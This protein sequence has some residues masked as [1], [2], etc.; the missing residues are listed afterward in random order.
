MMKK[1]KDGKEYI[2]LQEVC[3]YLNKHFL[4]G[5]YDFYGLEGITNNTVELY[6]D[7]DTSNH[8]KFESDDVVFIGCYVD[9]LDTIDGIAVVKTDKKIHFRDENGDLPVYVELAYFKQDFVNYLDKVNNEM[10]LLVYE[11][12]I[13]EINNE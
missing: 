3:N 2:T 4:N 12:E 11:E 13:E 6:D 1:N 5:E 10:E 9:F 7:F 8:Y